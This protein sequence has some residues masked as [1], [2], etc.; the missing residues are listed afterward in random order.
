MASVNAYFV[1]YRA[2]MHA[3]AGFGPDRSES[4]AR[5]GS[6]VAAGAQFAIH[7]DFNL[8]V[9][10]L[11]PLSVAGIAATRLA[12]DGETVLAPGERISVERAL[13][14]IT[15]DAAHVLSRDHE[16]GSI[17]PG[18]FADFAVLADDPY[19]CDARNLAHIE[20]VDTVLAGESTKN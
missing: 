12:D 11:S 7:S 14:A 16:I 20:V 3:D 4:T 13:R 2:Q 1:K 5:L 6:L 18:K 19:E 9:T 17:E 10:P 8:V 15:V